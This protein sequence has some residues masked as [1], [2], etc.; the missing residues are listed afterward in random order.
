MRSEGGKKGQKAGARVQNAG[1]R[2]I[3]QEQ[4][5]EGMSKGQKAGASIRC[6]SNGKKAR[7]G[8]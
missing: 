7:K 1:A 5:S 8:S 4:N 3:R 6:R 2:V